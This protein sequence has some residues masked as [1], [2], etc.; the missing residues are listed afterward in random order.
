MTK[1]TIEDWVWFYHK[2]GITVIP[3]KEKDKRP[4]ISTWADYQH[5][6]PDD[7]K[8]QFWLDQGKFENI[9]IVC[10]IASNNLV[11]IDIDDETIVEKIGI[12]L[13]KVHDQGNWVVKTGKGYHIY[14][15]HKD[16]PEDTKKHDDLHI[17][18]R[19]NACYVVAP[20]SVHP[21]GHQYEFLFDKTMEDLKPLKESDVKLTF[22]QM[23]KKLGGTKK[24][25]WV[26]D[27][28]KKGVSKGSRNDSAFR[29]A[30][31][32]RDKGLDP[33]EVLTVLTDWNKKNDPP[34]NK[35]ELETCIKSSFTG[36]R[37][38]TGT[39]TLQDVYD[40]VGK[41]L[42][43]SDYDR[44]DTILATVLTNQRPGDPVWLFI[45]GNSGDWKS[46]FTN[47]LA[48]LP[49]CRKLD[50][51]TKNSLATGKKDAADLGMKLVNNSTILLFPDMAALTS[52]KAEDKNAVWGQF[53]TLYDGDIFKETG[54]GVT[55]AYEN[56]HVTIIACATS[57]IRDEILIH[58]QLGTRELIYDTAADIVDNNKKITAALN[59][60][61][62]EEEMKRDISQVV[63]N[64]FNGRK[65]K[66]FPLSEEMDLF[67]KKEANRLS[68][69]RAGTAVDRYD[70]EVISDVDP[71]VP[72]RAAKQFKKLYSGL[73]SI[74]DNYPDKK[75]KKIISHIVDS[76]GNKLRK[77]IMKML[78]ETDEWVKATDIAY[79]TKIGYRSVK[80]QLSILFNLDLIDR[81]IESEGFGGFV[82]TD[83][84]GNEQLRG[85]HYRDVEY[86]K[87]NKKKFEQ[88]ELKIL[89][90]TGGNT[91]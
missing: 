1:K 44:I 66:E 88:I 67:I 26:K 31:I 78:Q 19:A 57:A 76:T 64:F 6:Q 72:T 74:D 37:Q 61:S 55:K 68:I 5:M 30:C 9:G 23:V 69:L 11:V 2:Q 84:N 83:Y 52:M 35:R 87:W 29:L 25:I 20:P 50:Q 32:Y 65:Y 42:Y 56:C 53:R 80:Q 46:A 21:S 8:I 38:V 47:S 48:E 10:G 33:S 77:K 18:Y 86:F 59:N 28:L 16:N 39:A 45:V 73:K 89:K 54:S 71:E 58:A 17:E 15:K 79:K 14:C 41:Y 82:T 3:V 22:D 70:R 13:K 12:D 49:N 60:E 4:N 34:L 90:S 27:D 63:L 75:I 85:Q 36:N 40:V 62:C 7:K 43:I 51:I 91:Y 81:K 24:L